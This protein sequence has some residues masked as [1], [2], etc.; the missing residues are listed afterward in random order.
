MRRGDIT[1]A[2]HDDTVMN[3]VRGNTEEDNYQML[4]LY[5]VRIQSPG[6]ENRAV[7]KRAQWLWQ[8]GWPNG[9]LANEMNHRDRAGDA[10]PLVA[11]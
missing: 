2:G 8:A 9:Q 5:Y 1:S 4:N 10:T 6:F 3:R 7:C 11:A